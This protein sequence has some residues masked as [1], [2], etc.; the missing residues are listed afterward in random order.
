MKRLIIILLIP[1]LNFNCSEPKIQT[2][3]LIA[4]NEKLSTKID[5]L[6]ELLHKKNPENN[7]WYDSGF[8]GE[9]LIENGIKNPVVFI[10]KSLRKNPNLIPLEAVLGGTM[11]FGKI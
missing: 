1:A 3:S 4:D 10:K 7:Y 8:D 2:K 6:T 11:H 5:S 9:N